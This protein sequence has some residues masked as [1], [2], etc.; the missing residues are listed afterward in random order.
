MYNVEVYR[1]VYAVSLKFQL[2]SSSD[3]YI[4]IIRQSMVE[5]VFTVTMP[6]FY[7][8]NLIP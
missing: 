7:V 5:N 6:L 4:V 1:Y 2:P 8:L 3:S